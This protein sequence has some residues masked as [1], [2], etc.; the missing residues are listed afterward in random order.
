MEKTRLAVCIKDE[1]YK[2]RFVNCIMKHY[3]EFFEVH[4]VNHVCVLTEE[5]Y[6][7]FGIIITDEYEDIGAEFVEENVCFVLQE[8]TKK[9]ELTNQN[10]YY[11]EKY[12]EVYKIMEE[13]QKFVTGNI[14]VSSRYNRTIYTKKIGVYSLTKEYMQ[15]PFAALL[16]EVLGENQKVLLLDLQAFS[17]LSMEVDTEDTLGIED[18]I[19]IASMENYTINRLSAS[20]GHEQTWDYIYPAKNCSCLTEIGNEIYQ[21]IL[22]ILEKEK[23]Y[24]YIIIN[25]GTMFAGMVELM[26]NCYELYMLTERKEEKNYREQDFIKEM[27][28]R[29]KDSILQKIIWIEVSAGMKNEFSWKQVSKN[30]LWGTMGDCVRERYWVNG[31]DGADL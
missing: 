15:I 19:A 8:E 25:F 2:L 7:S 4:V 27:R 22:M 18:M 13:V 26:E 9:T 16:A 30:W 17:G 11:I 14:Y 29:G 28:G 3:K 24:D 23:T 20:I 21:K 1:E 31:K 10:L 5:N 6:K 12:Q